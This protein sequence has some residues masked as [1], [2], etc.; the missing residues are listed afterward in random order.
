MIGIGD[1]DK[2]SLDSGLQLRINNA[3]IQLKL[4]S[5]RSPVICLRIRSEMQAW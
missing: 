1:K 3:T 2:K 4:N 5:L